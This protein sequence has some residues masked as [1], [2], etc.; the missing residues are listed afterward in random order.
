MIVVVAEYLG[1]SGVHPNVVHQGIPFCA[2]ELCPSYD[3]K[4]CGLVGCRPDGICEPAV[5]ELVRRCTEAPK[6]P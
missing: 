1:L 4:R 6:H 2:R 3:G 5:V